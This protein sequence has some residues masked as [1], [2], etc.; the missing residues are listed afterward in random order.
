MAIYRLSAQ[1]IGRSSG[2]SVTAAAAYRSAEILV[3]DRTGIKFD[4]TRRQ[5]VA[6]TEILAPAGSPSWVFDRAELWN[7]VEQ[8]ERRQDAQLAREIQLALPHELAAEE[9]V[10]LVREFVKDN[11]VQKGMVADISIHRAH[12]KG[13]DRNEHCHILLTTRA[14]TAVGFGPKERAWNDRDLLCGWRENWA[15]D[16]N[17]ALER[18]RRS[19]RIDH[20]T[21]EEQ[22]REKEK[23]A[24]AARAQG[25]T[26]I[27]EVFEIEAVRL[28][29]EPAPK[30]GA[31]AAA[32]ERRGVETERVTRWR[33]VK[34]RNDERWQL[35]KLVLSLRSRIDALRGDLKEMIH[36]QR[37]QLAALWSRAETAFQRVTR[38]LNDRD[39]SENEIKR[40][41]PKNSRLSDRDRQPHNRTDRDLIG[42]N[43]SRTRPR[44]RDD[45]DRDR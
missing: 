20:R 8:V 43:S 15:R 38:F 34:A 1:I 45:P 25:D 17:A 36:D 22:R 18:A 27:A 30:V 32:M 31:I 5:G 39:A 4:Y 13:D 19:E 26:D 6:H 42:N 28:D 21:L 3:D 44:N 24:A 35:G 14:P 40:G 12:R 2:R 11:F 7:R 10:M 16:V 23:M 9:R 29:R 33:E 41:E 37:E